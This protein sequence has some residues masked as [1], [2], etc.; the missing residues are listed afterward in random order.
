MPL[1]RGQTTVDLTSYHTLFVAYADGLLGPTAILL[2]AEPHLQHPH[3]TM[4]V[5]FS[6]G[7][8]TE[9]FSDPMRILMDTIA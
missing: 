2:F 8:M 7:G 6:S 4:T 1:S 3:S 5:R 9:A